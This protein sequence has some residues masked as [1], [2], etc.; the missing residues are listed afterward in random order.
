MTFIGRFNPSTIFHYY[1]QQL[2]CFGPKAQT[3]P[4]RKIRA[5]RVSRPAIMY[6]CHFFRDAG[7]FH[8]MRP[9]F[10]RGKPWRFTVRHSEFIAATGTATGG[11]T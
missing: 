6:C 4:L 7:A 5:E 11:H 1:P 2:L 10:G 8:C 9:R 3:V